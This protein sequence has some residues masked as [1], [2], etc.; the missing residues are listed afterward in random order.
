M[1]KNKLKI[2]ILTIVNILL[3][4]YNIVSITYVPSG[5]YNNTIP[6]NVMVL[7]EEY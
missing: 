5:N 3:L 4:F 7:E 6:S 1:S 2:T